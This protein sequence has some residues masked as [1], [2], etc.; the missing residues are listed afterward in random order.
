MKKSTVFPKGAFRTIDEWDEFVNNTDPAI[1][2]HAPSQGPWGGA[3][4]SYGVDKLV[5]STEILRRSSGDHSVRFKAPQGGGLH[6]EPHELVFCWGGGRHTFLFK[7]FWNAYAYACKV[8]QSK[9]E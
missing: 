4:G 3:K 2:W 6:A 1:C 8:E 9:N 5:G 7:N